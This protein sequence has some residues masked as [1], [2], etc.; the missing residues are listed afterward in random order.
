MGLKINYSKKHRHTSCYREPFTGEAK[1]IWS[2]GG[3]TFWKGSQN[4]AYRICYFRRTFKVPFKNGVLLT[5]HVSADSRYILYFNG[6]C[7]GR[8]PAKGDINHQFYDTICL[9]SIL[10]LGENVLAAVVISF[11][12]SWPLYTGKGGPCS[13]M[14]VSNG[15]ILDGILYD[16]KGETLET[17]HSDSRWKA[18]PDNSYR[19]I[20]DS[21]IT[22]QVVGMGEDLDGTK[23]PWDWQCPGYD[24]S[25]WEK[26]EELAP[27]CKWL[28]CHSPTELDSPLPYR[29][30]PRMIPF[31]EEKEKKFTN[32]YFTKEL[33]I[34]KILKLLKEDI[35]VH[36]PSKTKASF[37]LDAGKLTTAFP[38]LL[39]NGGARSTIKFTYTETWKKGNGE[40]IPK[41]DFEGKIIGNY[42]RYRGSAE[43]YNQIYEP[44][45]WRTFRY[46]L[47]EIKTAN[48][49]LIL[50]KLFYRYTAYPLT[51][52]ASFSSSNPLHRK[53]W[54]ISWHTVRLCCHETYEDCPCYEQLQYAEDSYLEMLFS[55]YVSGD[56]R[57]AKQAV[58]H[59]NWSRTYEGLTKSRYPSRVPQYLISWSFSWIRM[60]RDYWWHTGDTETVLRCID[61]VISTLEWFEKY[62][63]N[64]G[65]LDHLPYWKFV[66]WVES[67]PFGSPPGADKISTIINLQYATTLQMAVDLFDLGNNKDK[68]KECLSIA[69][70]INDYVNRYCWSEKNG[71]YY[72]KPRGPEVSE[73]VNAWAIL[74]GA[75]QDERMMKTAKNLIKGEILAKSSFAGRFYTFRA[76]SKADFYSKATPLFDYWKKM[77]H[78]GLTTWPEVP[79]PYAR[80]M[81]HGWSSAPIYEFLAEILGIKPALPGFKEIIITPKQLNLTWAKGCVPLP[82][83]GK[84]KVEWKCTRDRKFCLIANW[85]A[86]VKGIVVLPGCDPK[87]VISTGK[88]MEFIG[89]VE[90]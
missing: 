65:V 51:E 50:K 21:P 78:L 52:K 22:S 49:P 24:D 26:T 2:Q 5:V 84:V 33:E 15:F 38:I 6:V 73:C 55:G 66:D 27:G 63:N 60:V 9:D 44:L 90:C 39:L 82:R 56:W 47:V 79:W 45:H 10:K 30:L 1:W 69:K 13:V 36:I 48:Q 80:S 18:L 86:G 77:G 31:L 89:K 75:A 41:A 3:V 34:G 58:L 42:D 35:P 61:G 83:G 76:I 28:S 64:N 16:K 68:S 74:S 70:S 37:I 59:F 23:Y 12:P 32:V 29:L 17:L 19:Q 4:S 43:K 14:T 85:P 57:L 67:W 40:V 8:G 11:A 81:C 88:P 62:L 71:W 53:I 7:I 54:Q 25:S 20:Y 87:K 72:D 46:I